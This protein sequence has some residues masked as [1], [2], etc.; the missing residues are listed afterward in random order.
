MSDS[1]E[2]T[3]VNVIFTLILLTPLIPCCYFAIAMVKKCIK[4]TKKGSKSEN[5]SYE[6]F[7]GKKL[8]FVL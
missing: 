3:T 7:Q 6:R 8:H 2:T 5:S 4:S 1:T